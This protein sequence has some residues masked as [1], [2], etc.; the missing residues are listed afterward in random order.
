[1]GAVSSEYARLFTIGLCGTAMTHAAPECYARMMDDG[2]CSKRAFAVDAVH[3]CEEQCEAHNCYEACRD[4]CDAPEEGCVHVE[5]G[6][7]APV[8]GSFTPDGSTEVYQVGAGG[9]APSSGRF[10]PDGGSTSAVARGSESQ[11]C[12]QCVA[13][14][15]CE[16]CVTC[17]ADVESTGGGAGGNL[18]NASNVT[19]AECSCATDA[20]MSQKFEPESS[21]FRAAGVSHLLSSCVA[22]TCVAVVSIY[23]IVLRA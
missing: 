10:C 23:H 13:E 1:M 4:V 19:M 17:H 12:Q 7:V 14:T 21:I 11:A 5:A 18:S 2:R 9:E 8:N 16:A 3:P 20:C 6:A 22:E 15:G